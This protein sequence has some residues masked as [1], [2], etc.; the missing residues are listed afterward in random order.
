MSILCD[1]PQVSLGQERSTGFGV[2]ALYHICSHLLEKR[3]KE[4]SLIE[5]SLFVFCLMFTVFDTSAGV[6]IPQ[7]TKGGLYIAIR[8]RLNQELG[9]EFTTVCGNTL[10]KK[11]KFKNL[12]TFQIFPA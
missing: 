4:N 12:T 9:V 2:I 10:L 8:R 11:I 7:P 1:H 3:K 5:C 6:E